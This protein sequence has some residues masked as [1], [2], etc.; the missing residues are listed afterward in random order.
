MK[1]LSKLSFWYVPFSIKFLAAL[2][3]SISLS[4]I[5]GIMDYVPLEERAEHTYYYP[6]G[7]TLSISILISMAVLLFLILPLS[8][9]ADK[10][11]AS[12]KIN[13]P[14][15]KVILVIVT[16]FL[17]GLGSGLLFSIFVFKWAAFE[18]TGPY[19]YLIITAFVFLLWQLGLNRLLRRGRG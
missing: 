16:Y 11:I 17:L 1:E 18:Y 19:P 13:G 5:V 14:V 12:Q 10:V 15:A 8:I 4:L 2:L 9:F 6:F 7:Y 3:T